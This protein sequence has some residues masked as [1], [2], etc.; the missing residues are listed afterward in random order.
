MNNNSLGMKIVM[1]AVAVALTAYFSF[2]AYNYFT[3]P[4]YTTLAYNYV[5][6]EEA[7]LSGYVVRE[8]QVLPGEASG[9]LRLNRGEGERVS[10]GGKVAT[11]YADQAS[12]DR[13]TEIDSLT[14]RIEQLQYAEEA[15]VGAEVALKL[16]NQIMQSLL[17]YRASVTAEKFYEA[18]N[19]GTELRAMVLKRDYSSAEG[20]DLKGEIET[21]QAELKA[22]KS[23]SEGSVRS[24]RVS[25]TGLYSAVVDG[26]EQI[27]TPS[28]VAEMTPSAFS[29]LK[30]DGAVS[31]N[32]GK[33]I[34]GDGWYYAA[35]MTA[36]AA[37]ELQEDAE[38]LERAG[39]HLTLR[40]TKNIERDLPVTI[41]S[42]GPE[43]N[44]KAVVLF[45]GTTYAQEL[46]LLRRQSAQVIYHTVE[47]IRV[48]L[49]GLRIRTTQTEQEDGTTVETKTTGVYCVVGMEARFKPVEVLHSGDGFALVRSTAAADRE[50]L[51]LRPGDEVIISARDLYDGKVVG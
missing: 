40:F 28:A 31:S 30:A 27:L 17:A 8:E 9:L 1:A 2:Q 26:F 24:I 15:A 23:Q 32:T 33:L 10:T 21:L 13:Q 18:E 5:V 42:V 46:T 4:L 19:Q 22:L 16:D 51:R 36:E 41:A 6:E 14:M 25:E 48:P 20:R 12:L 11:V 29:A 45:H 39:G 50:N 49:D 47:G 37:E 35:V 3:D 38:A 7:T 43:E 34:L 44:G